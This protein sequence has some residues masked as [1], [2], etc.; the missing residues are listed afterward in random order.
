MI[1]KALATAAATASIVGVAAGAAPEAVAMGTSH[2]GPSSMNGNGTRQ[3]FGNST[4]HGYM[5]P[6]IGLIQ[7]S[8]NKPCVALP[9]KANIGSLVGAVPISVQDLNLLSNPQIQQCT[10]NST[11]AKG[12]E[13]LAHL[14][15]NIP[16]WS[17]NGGGGKKR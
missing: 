6:Q 7:G 15:S 14:L 5:S 4:T 8:L 1:K 16:L 12:D 3:Y 11:Q 9:S 13:S 2:H 10:E 17:G